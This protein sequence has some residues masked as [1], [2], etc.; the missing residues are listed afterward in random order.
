MQVH[1]ID[2]TYEL[3]RHHFALPSHRDPNGSEVAAVRG[4][5][6]SVLTMLESGATHIGVATDQVITSFRN[7]LYDGYKTGEGVEPELLCQFPLLENALAALGVTVWPMVELEADDAMASAASVARRDPRVERIFICTP[8]KDLAQCVVD[9]VVVQFDR[10]NDRLIDEAA[11]RDKFGVEPTSIPDFLALVGDNADGFPGLA[12]WGAKSAAAVLARYGTIAAIPQASMD[13]DVK[14]RGAVKLAATLATQR[15]LA[16]L[17]KV[18]ATLRTDGD[19]GNVD[20]WRWTG[21]TTE[22]EAWAQRLGAPSLV[23]RAS[24]LAAGRT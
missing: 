4:V 22:L 8:D 13:W 10:R 1:L 17:F 21:P 16:E 14:V 23:A 24:K 2:G 12:G 19:V 15:D 5:L 18:L 11:V 9:P 20:D 3:F 7:D 6:F